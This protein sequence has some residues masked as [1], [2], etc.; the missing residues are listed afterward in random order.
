VITL[1]LGGGIAL[2]L[3]LLLTPGIIWAL[4][5]LNLG[6][7]IRADTP[8]RHQLKHGTPSMGGVAIVIAAVTGY[9]SGVWLTGEEVSAAAWLVLLMMVGM[10]FVGW[11]DDYL[12]VRRQNSI[13]LRPGLKF[14]GQFLVTTPFAILALTLTD[15][16][17]NTLASTA[18]SWARDID[19]LNFA[20]W[21]GPVIGLIVA[22]LWINLI[23]AATTH[24]VNL[25]DGLDGLAAGA[26]I[27]VAGGYVLIGFWQNQQSCF[28]ELLP[29][30]IESCYVVA[31][32]ND[33]ARVA[34][35]MVGAL[36]GFL[37]WNTNPARIFM[38][39]SGAFAIGGTIAALAVL[40][41]TEL[42]LVI[43]GGLFMII[44]L[45]VIIQIGVWRLSK[46]TVRV[47][48]SAPL[49]HHFELLGWEEITIVVRFWIVA[50]LFVATGLGLFYIEWIQ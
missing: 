38:G 33:L 39:D 5:K 22:V 16:H 37:W 8:E 7:L 24:A 32:P 41:R 4:R 28:A 23:S 42:L 49:H 17:G 34:A 12:K 19:W 47:F 14:L 6:Q 9:L 48:K 1:L 26:A 18:V 20:L 50:G 30:A 29:E 40:S 2:V 35:A 15:Q 36:I 3:S 21:F 46:R 25:T 11:I 44:T 31:Y 27:F 10:G 45:S 43:T 13:G